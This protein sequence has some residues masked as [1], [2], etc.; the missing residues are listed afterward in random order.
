M[1]APQSAGRG[2]APRRAAGLAEGPGSAQEEA[3]ARRPGDD[4]AGLEDT[5]H[6]PGHL[7]TRADHRREMGSR[8]DRGFAEEQCLMMMENSSDPKS[9]I[10]MEQA[11]EAGDHRLEG[12]EYV[13]DHVQREAR[14]VHRQ[15]AHIGRLPGGDL[16]I[17]QRDRPGRRSPLAP[18]QRDQLAGRHDPGHDLAPIERDPTETDMPIR[19]EED[20]GRF[21]LIGDGEPRIDLPELGRFEKHRS[22]V[23]S[24]MRKCRRQ[25]RLELIGLRRAS[26]G[27]HFELSVAS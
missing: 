7:A 19:H 22:D 27:F 1:F 8:Q 18:R 24:G 23:V 13:L 16:A 6:S 3:P 10:L 20:V 4:G 12:V 21:A 14:I 9:R 15:G 5:K 26:W 2:P 11:I 25:E 17:R